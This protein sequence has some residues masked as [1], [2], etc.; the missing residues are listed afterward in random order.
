MLDPEEIAEEVD[1]DERVSGDSKNDNMFS[2][3]KYL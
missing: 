3:L 2:F 1:E